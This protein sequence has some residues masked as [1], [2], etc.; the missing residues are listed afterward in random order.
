MI[1]TILFPARGKLDVF[2]ELNPPHTVSRFGGC[3]A[4]GGEEVAKV[5]EDISRAG[6]GVS[7]NGGGVSVLGNGLAG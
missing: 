6:E 1:V 3:F 4:V 7:V 2:L 5:G